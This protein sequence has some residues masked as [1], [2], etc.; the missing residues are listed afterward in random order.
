[1]LKLAAFFNRPYKIS[2]GQIDHYWGIS[3][4][5]WGAPIK[6]TGT[7]E[8]FAQTPSKHSI[9]P[10][11]KGIEVDL[12]SRRSESGMRALIAVGPD[13]LGG[14]GR[15][16]PVTS[17]A[18]PAQEGGRVQGLSS[19]GEAAS[20][21]HRRRR[22]DLGRMT[23]SSKFTHF[24]LTSFWH[25][26]YFEVTPSVSFFIFLFLKLLS[27]IHFHIISRLIWN[28]E[29]INHQVSRPFYISLLIVKLMLICWITIWLDMK[30]REYWSSSKSAIPYFPI[31]SET[32]VITHVNLLNHNL[33][34]KS[35][36]P[37][38]M[39]S[40]QYMW[41]WWQQW[42]CKCIHCNLNIST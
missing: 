6:E 25:Y 34:R 14:S 26:F 36:M 37:D 32:H 12:L 18:R 24:F 28:G 3:T 2:N 8:A 5:T 42:Y 9:D 23:N 1:M 35:C 31:N 15:A 10:D 40:M 30:Q 21:G 17:P 29:S 19:A 11:L 22:W 41:M 39:G 33:A 7:V 13:D 4:S 16:R 27:P 20:G 38:P